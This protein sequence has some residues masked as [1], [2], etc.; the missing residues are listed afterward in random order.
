MGRAVSSTLLDFVLDILDGDILDGGLE[1][2]LE[3]SP[4]LLSV[5]STALKLSP[6]H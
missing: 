2:N 3:E 6:T 4:D 5:P 1:L